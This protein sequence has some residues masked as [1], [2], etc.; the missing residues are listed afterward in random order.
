MAGRPIGLRKGKTYARDVEALG[1]LQTAVLQDT[2]IPREVRGPL[3]DDVDLLK[4]RV[5]ELVETYQ[6]DD[7]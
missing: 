4:R 5:Q 6:L 2:R 3:A 7:P 1:R